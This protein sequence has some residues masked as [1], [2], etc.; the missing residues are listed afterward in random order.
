MASWPYSDALSRVWSSGT[1]LCLFYAAFSC[2]YFI[3]DT[4]LCVRNLRAFGVALLVHAVVC[5]GGYAIIFCFG[6]IPYYG[7]AYLLWEVCAPSSMRRLKPVMQLSTPFLN[8]RGF[9]WHLKLHSSRLYVANAFVLL[10]VFF[11][12]RIVFGFYMIFW[13]W[14]DLLSVPSVPLLPSLYFFMSSFVTGSLPPASL[15]FLPC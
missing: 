13:T 3:W 10:F 8:I 9:L 14:F 4:Y 5:G 6:F 12:V 7:C 11:A 1:P 15:H 2:G